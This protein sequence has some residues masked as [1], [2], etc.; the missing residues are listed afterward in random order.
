MPRGGSVRPEGAK[1]CSPGLALVAS[2]GS[3][4]AQR[5]QAP[6]GRRQFPQWKDSRFWRRQAAPPPSRTA[7]TL[8][9]S[10]G[11][12]VQSYMFH[13]MNGRQLFPPET[14]RDVE[15]IGKAFEGRR[16][17]VDFVSRAT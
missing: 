5:P 8:T 14:L 16:I 9:R 10:G 15:T 7:A 4:R 17:Q 11:L 1:A 13:R 2:P 12:G 6:T 3:P